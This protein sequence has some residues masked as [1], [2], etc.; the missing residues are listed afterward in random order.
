MSFFNRKI[1]SPNVDG[2]ERGEKYYNEIYSEDYPAEKYIPIYEIIISYINSLKLQEINIL[3]VG[4]GVGEFA[5][6]IQNIGYNRMISLE[7]I[8][9]TFSCL[10]FNNNSITGQS[11]KVDLGL[12]IEIKY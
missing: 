4:C 8:Y 6:Q 12:S 1:G 11:I 3:D 5:N 2:I 7:D 9:N 10:C